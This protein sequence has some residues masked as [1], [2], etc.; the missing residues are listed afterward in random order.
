MTKRKITLELV[1]QDLWIGL[2]WR[3]SVDRFDLWICLVPCI[4]IHYSVVSN[5]SNESI[6][7]VER[8]HLT[9]R[10]D[11]KPKSGWSTNG[12]EFTRGMHHQ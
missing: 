4:P 10:S 2:F 8:R 7:P 1:P 6:L 5:K 12:N 11:P 3:K 9:A